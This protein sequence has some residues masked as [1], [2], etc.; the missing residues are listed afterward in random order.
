MT[1]QLIKKYECGIVHFS[2]KIFEDERGYF[3]EV[4]RENSPFLSE[5]KF[6]QDNLSLSKKGVVRGLHYQKNPYEQ[7]KL[8]TCISG[9]IWDVA[10]DLRPKSKSF[11]KHWFFYLDNKIPE[12]VYLP[13]GFAHGFAALSSDTIISY[14]TTKYYEKD[15][16]ITLKWND[17]DLDIPW[18]DSCHI[19]SEKDNKGISLQ[20]FLL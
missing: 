4:F 9:K 12:S 5:L 13:E 2:R 15:S 3:S 18:P 7:G 16:E 10:V 20:E 17:R 1:F 6:V 19:V 8:V 14:K 11:L